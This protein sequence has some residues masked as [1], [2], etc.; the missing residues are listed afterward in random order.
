MD[1]GGGG[2][3][4]VAAVAGLVARW[5]EAENKAAAVVRVT[6]VVLKKDGLGFDDDDNEDEEALMA[7]DGGG[8]CKIR[9]ETSLG[10]GL[11]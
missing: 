1:G 2:E 5:K 9:Y 6:Q 3:T 7:R 11:R 8:F 4:R 10:W